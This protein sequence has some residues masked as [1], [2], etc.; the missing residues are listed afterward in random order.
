MR[1]LNR[2][3]HES[4]SVVETRKMVY[5]ADLTLVVNKPDSAMTQLASIAKKFEGYVLSSGTSGSVIRVKSENLESAISA[6]SGL[7]KITQKRLTGEDV[8]D[9]YQDFQIRLSN[10][11]KARERYLELLGQAENV[12]A[13]LRVEKELERLNQVI[14]SLKGQMNRLDHLE[15]YSTI[16]LTINERKKPGL[17]GYIG[18]GL[19]HSVKWL[20]VRN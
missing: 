17:L 4:H 7:G 2:P 19:Y 13:A 10:S 5:Q 14:D 20:F 18:I 15:A 9:T 12:E 6:I 11:E 16:T 3:F 1:S 8:S